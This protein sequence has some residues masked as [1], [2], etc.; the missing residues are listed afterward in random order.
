MEQVRHLCAH[1]HWNGISGRRRPYACHG[2]KRNTSISPSQ[3]CSVLVAGGLMDEPRSTCARL[4]LSLDSTYR[5]WLLHLISPSHPSPLPPTQAALR[6]YIV[7]SHHPGG[8]TADL[9]ALLISTFLGLM[10]YG[11]ST[12]QAYMFYD[13]EAKERSRV[14][15]IM[16]S[17][18]LALQTV[19]C[20]LC[21]HANYALLIG[22]A[23]S[24]GFPVQR[25]WSLNVS[26][27]R[28][29]SSPFETK[30]KVYVLKGNWQI[31]SVFSAAI[32]CTT[33]S[34]FARRV[35]R[36]WPTYGCF[37]AILVGILTA[38]QLGTVIASSVLLY[39][40]RTEQLI[41]YIRWLICAHSAMVMLASGLL[42]GALIW[43][44]WR[45]RTGFTRTDHIIA[46][47]CLYTFNTGMLVGI[48]SLFS[49][50]FVV[51]WPTSLISIS[52]EVVATNL[53]VVS[54]LSQLN[55][56]QSLSGGDQAIIVCEATRPLV[57]VHARTSPTS[58]MFNSNRR[59]SQGQHMSVRWNARPIEF[60][61]ITVTVTREVRYDDEL[62]G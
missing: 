1:L 13:T 4:L 42:A 55:S 32:F 37:I 39:M 14:L 48:T 12:H 24:M 46:L 38:G 30:L 33:H 26:T 28:A 60:P 22:D 47:L 8:R 6:M 61:K 16:V 53:Y 15:K 9:G 57:Q 19:H 34:I 18:V 52:V 36:L 50:I 7:F 54:L 45:S 21:M 25:G 23:M 41:S 56:R 44:L 58:G 17:V 27:P 31:L 43:Y 62:K 59:V 35:S 51:L 5:T 10:F 2:G 49:L 20:G 11:V 40:P 29:R 3:T